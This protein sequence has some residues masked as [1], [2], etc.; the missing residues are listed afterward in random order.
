M[1]FFI[2]AAKD[3]G[4]FLAARLTERQKGGT[5]RKSGSR[6]ARAETSSNDAGTGSGKQPPIP[7]GAPLKPRKV[8]EHQSALVEIINTYTDMDDEMRT[9]LLKV[10]GFIAMKG[11]TV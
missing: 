8:H 9:A 7:E 10:V 4:I 3:S 2:H 1:T 5:G 11:V 6:R